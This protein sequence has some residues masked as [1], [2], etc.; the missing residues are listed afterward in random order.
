M[1]LVVASACNRTTQAPQQKASEPPQRH[2]ILLV[3]LD[4]MRADAIGPEADGVQ[5]PEF[6][7][8]A[9]RGRL[10]RQAYAA[11]PETLPS[12]TSMFTGLYPAG[13]GVHENARYVSPTLPLAAERLHAAGYRTTAFVS[14]FVLARRFGLARGFDV[15]KELTN[16]LKAAHAHKG[17]AFVEIFQN[18]I[19]YNKDR[20]EDFA[21]PKGA[22]GNQLWLKHGE[23]MLF[24]SE[25]SGGVKGIVLNIDHLHL[26]VVD[27]PDGDWQA[28]GVIVHD[29]KNRAIA[30]MLVEMP[31]GPFPMALGVLYDDPRPTF[32]DMVLGQ[33]A[34]AS[35]GKKRDLAGLLAK[36]QTWTV[37][38]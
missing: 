5:T 28:A 12:H 19:V 6:N 18:C 3:T 33:D 25:K 16:V 29:V 13:H 36:G 10:Y 1:F 11:V 31:F 8:V 26:E 9:A 4:T 22:E 34:K 20:F 35:E 37:E 14:A 21:A 30:H 38:A 2:S 7:A 27:V 32:E 17:A 23:P 15:S 24:G